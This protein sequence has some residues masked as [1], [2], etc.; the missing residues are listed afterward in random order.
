MTWHIIHSECSY[1]YNELIL[2][3]LTT[4]PRATLPKGKK[5]GKPARWQRNW[6]KEQTEATPPGFS[7]SSA[8]GE[9][10][11]WWPWS[12]S[13]RALNHRSQTLDAPDGVCWAAGKA[14]NLRPLPRARCDGDRS[15]CQPEM[16]APGW[17]S[18]NIC[19]CVSSTWNHTPSL[20]D[21]CWEGK[22][23]I[24]LWLQ[25]SGDTEEQEPIGA[26]QNEAG[27]ARPSKG[28]NC[29]RKLKECCLL[30]GVMGV[31]ESFCAES[32]KASQGSAEANQCCTELSP[33]WNRTPTSSGG[34]C[35]SRMGPACRFYPLSLHREEIAHLGSSPST[36]EN[37]FSGKL[38][39]WD[40]LLWSH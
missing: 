11:G 4:I 12:R 14:D 27:A 37:D 1:C 29:S 40:K 8:A 5:G 36:E 31:G 10:A 25:L 18:S 15:E 21:L 6:L 39:I 30:S 38:Y 19:P 7:P 9:R 3:F 17:L 2:L 26:Q 16:P 28:T 24:S 33:R 22:E 20:M 32:H 35:A 13:C 34:M 23:L